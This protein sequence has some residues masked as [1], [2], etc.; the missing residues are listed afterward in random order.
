MCSR[1]VPP[2][3]S[4]CLK[5]FSFSFDS[6]IFIPLPLSTHVVI[7]LKCLSTINS[8]SLNQEETEPSCDSFNALFK[9]KEQVFR[10]FFSHSWM[11]LF[12]I[13]ILTYSTS[14]Q[15]SACQWLT[16]LLVSDPLKYSCL[17]TWL[18]PPN[19]S[20]FTP[21]V[22]KYLVFH[23]KKAKC[24][25]FN[26]LVTPSDLSPYIMGDLCVYY[27]IF[28]TFICRYMFIEMRRNVFLVILVYQVANCRRSLGQDIHYLFSG[29]T[30]RCPKRR[31]FGG[32]F[33]RH[34]Y[35]SYQNWS[36]S[37]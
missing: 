30:G 24:F 11:Q 27:F 33:P 25:P 14:I 21:E 22:V 9:I 12:I 16:M 31:W 13:I 35:Q 17:W 8:S 6:C 37:G 19:M 32:W 7:L 29:N 3:L 2:W 15:Y 10:G 5:C 4:L 26:H 23:K 18:Q 28:S 36:S 1:F 34:S 20:I